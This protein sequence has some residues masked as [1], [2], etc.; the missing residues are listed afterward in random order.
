[1]CAVLAW[2]ADLF[3]LRFR[4]SW[5]YIYIVHVTAMS[6][7]PDLPGDHK[8]PVHLYPGSGTMTNIPDPAIIRMLVMALIT[9]PLSSVNDRIRNLISSNPG[10][11]VAMPLSKVMS[12]QLVVEGYNHKA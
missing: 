8:E 7:V 4:N 12:H 1:M 3:P 5:L 6:T 9:R 11:N 2:L 10:A